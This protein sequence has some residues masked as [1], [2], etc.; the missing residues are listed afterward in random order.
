MQLRFWQTWSTPLVLLPMLLLRLLRMLRSMQ[1]R[2]VMVRHAPLLLRLSLK[3]KPA[4]AGTGVANREA[5]IGVAGGV[6]YR[7]AAI[8]VA[9]W[10]A[11]ITPLFRWL[12]LLL[13]RLLLLLLLLSTELGFRRRSA[14][15]G[16]SAMGEH[17]WDTYYGNHMWW[18]GTVV[19]ETES[20]N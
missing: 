16:A 17:M 13:L 2:L 11:A 6:A 19:T 18:S 5:A 4:T 9:E 8:G 3:R 1:L 20:D 14:P 10:E 7:D 15:D 12:R